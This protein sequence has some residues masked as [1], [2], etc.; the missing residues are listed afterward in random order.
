MN[1]IKRFLIKAVGNKFKGNLPGL[2]DSHCICFHGSILA[3]E[4]LRIK[5]PIEA[6]LIG[7]ILVTESMFRVFYLRGLEFGVTVVL[8]YENSTSWRCGKR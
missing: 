6:A 1:R 2:Q 7:E 4:P 3:G 5:K 8:Y